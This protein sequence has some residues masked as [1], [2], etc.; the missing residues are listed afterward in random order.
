MA[1][2]FSSLPRGTH[3]RFADSDDGDEFEDRGVGLFSSNIIVESKDKLIDPKEDICLVDDLPL[4]FGAK[5][6]KDYEGIE[7]GH[8]IITI[9]EKRKGKRKSIRIIEKM[10]TEACMSSPF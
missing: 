3:I 8:E 7:G 6:E 9:L 10:P 2:S 5:N 1:T 4:V